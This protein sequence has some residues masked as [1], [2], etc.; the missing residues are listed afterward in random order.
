MT[1]LTGLGFLKANMGGAGA[2]AQFPTLGTTAV[3][4]ITNCKPADPTPT[5]MR[6]V[7]GQMTEV[8][9]PTL[10]ITGTVAGPTVV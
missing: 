3:V 1:Q 9:D 6:K 10:I 4:R 5:K 7:G 2:G 8:A